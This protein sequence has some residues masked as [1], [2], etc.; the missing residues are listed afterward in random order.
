M[1]VKLLTRHLQRRVVQWHTNLHG[2]VLQ[3]DSGTKTIILLVLVSV[4]G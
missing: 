1:A 4:G 3:I 2:I